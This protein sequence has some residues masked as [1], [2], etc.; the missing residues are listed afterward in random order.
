MQKRFLAIWFPYLRTDWFAR[1]QPE[2]KDIPFVLS[3]PDH[4]RMIITATNPIAQMQHIE[5]GMTV[6]DARTLV[7]SLQVLDDKPEITE[8]LLTNM[9][10][11]CIRYTPAVAID[12]PKGLILDVSGCTHL[13]GG[14]DK[15]MADIHKRFQDF[16]FQNQV[17]IA[18]TIGAAWAF[19]H[20]GKNM[21][22]YTGT[23]QKEALLVLPPAALRLEKETVERLEKLGLRT[24][25]HFINMPQTA[26]RRRF[27]KHM[28]MRLNQ[29][30]GNEEEGFIPVQPIEPY[31]ERLPCLEPIV[32][33]KGIEIALQKLLDTICHRLELE[34]KGLRLARF[35][36]FRMDG[37]IEMIEI[38]TNRPTGNPKHLFTLFEIKI[39][40]IEPD[41]GIE[42]FMLE[43]LRVEN[44]PRAQEKLWEDNTGITD[45]QLAELLDR[46]AIKIGG[47][48][49]QRYLPAEHYWPE[50]SFMAAGSVM[51]KSATNW[52]V[53]RPRPLYLLSNPNPIEV[54][55]PIPDY[56]P[57]LFRYKGKLHK[58]VKA[59]GPERIETEWWLQQ[60]LHRDY[61][62]VEDTAGCRYW[63]FRS[64]HYDSTRS[65][66]WYVHGFFA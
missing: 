37:K 49:I 53:Q 54:T 47:H 23:R 32:T 24:V 11:Y 22:A 1:R 17:V 55:A 62:T 34:Q 51:E 12:P 27:G 64:G 31:Q 25:N 26:L 48:N 57:M 40:S 7:P 30:L 58:I 60:G 35:S 5:T 20:F 43:A 42:L 59:D 8:S 36:G 28:L 29:A 19:V 41:L 44:L 38:G 63:L 16:G 56:P 39:D 52:Q 6:A 46:L 65:Y 45:T 14:E 3:L 18:D 15:Y 2:L 61:Y 66:Q 33:A 4:G 21:F 9:A 50:R 10:T 13:W